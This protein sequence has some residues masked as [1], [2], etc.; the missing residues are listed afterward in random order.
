MI[1]SSI[2]NLTRSLTI[3]VGFL[4]I[5]SQKEAMYKSTIMRNLPTIYK[6]IEYLMYIIFG[7]NKVINHR[8]VINF[9]SCTKQELSGLGEDDLVFYL[10]IFWVSLTRKEQLSIASKLAR[11]V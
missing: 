11:Q 8:L 3:L 10:F 1:Q 2:F 7:S 5:R 6:Y 9:F 4:D